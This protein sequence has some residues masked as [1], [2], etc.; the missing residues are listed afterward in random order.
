MNKKAVFFVTLMLT[1]IFVLPIYAGK[2]NKGNGA[3]NGPHF[4][5]NIIGVPKEKKGEMDNNGHRIFVK[6]WGSDTR[7][8]L[9]MG[10]TFKVIDGD[11]T[12]GTAELQLK[13]PYDGVYEPDVTEANYRIYV[14]ALGKPGGKADMSTGFYDEFGTWWQSLETVEFERKPGKST[15]KDETLKLTTIYVDIGDGLKRY[16][17]FGNALWDYAWDYDNF[18]LKLVQLRI[19]EV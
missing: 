18:G 2:D 13:D 3:P 9:T 8:M 11:G 14:R 15:F 1:S 7:I 10:D 4:N 6:L 12:D 16:D 5:L 17:L 19:Y